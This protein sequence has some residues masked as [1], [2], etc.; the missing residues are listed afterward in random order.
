[1]P[2]RGRAIGSRPPLAAC[3][4]DV[5]PTSILITTLRPFGPNLTRT[6][7]VR[8][9]MPRSIRSRASVRSRTSLAAMTI[10]LSVG[11]RSGGGAL[12]RGDPEAKDRNP[13]VPAF[14]GTTGMSME[15]RDF[16]REDTGGCR[17]PSER[18][19]LP[20]RT[21][22][23]SFLCQKVRQLTEQ[24]RRSCGH[25]GHEDKR[26]KLHLGACQADPRSTCH[27]S[28]RRPCATLR[29]APHPS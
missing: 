10:P 26:D 3:C 14:A 23:L 28:Q 20:K 19:N 15:A 4:P 2:Q 21:A 1:M 7:S 18:K 16:A 22:L 29:L 24:L 27:H 5:A 8:V 11:F 17:C 25:R 13:W 12:N 6:A 9:S